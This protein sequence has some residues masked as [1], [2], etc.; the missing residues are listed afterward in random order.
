MCCINCFVS[1]LCRCL[2]SVGRDA[3][4]GSAGEIPVC[5]RGV[6]EEPVSQPAEQV[7]KAAAPLAFP[8]HRLFLCHRA[9]F[10]HPSRGENAHRNSDKGHAAV[11]EQLQ[12]AVHADSIEE[13]AAVAVLLRSG[14][15]PTP[16]IK[17]FQCGVK[18]L[19]CL[20]QGEKKKTASGM[21]YLQVFQT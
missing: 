10:L 14:K 13:R 6:C 3:C 1:S 2:W 4:G 17:S 9:A 19:F 15:G 7:W 18:L 5:F 20:E 8:P 21:R 11:R 12:L 16:Q